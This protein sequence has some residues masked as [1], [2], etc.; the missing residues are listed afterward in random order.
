MGSWASMIQLI[1]AVSESASWCVLEWFPAGSDELLPLGTLVGVAVVEGSW[2][3]DVTTHLHAGSVTGSVKARHS[4]KESRNAPHFMSDLLV[5]GCCCLPLL[6][7]WLCME[8]ECLINEP[9]CVHLMLVALEQARGMATPV[10]TLKA[11]VV[12]LSCESVHVLT[13]SGQG[14]ALCLLGKHGGGPGSAWGSVVW[15]WLACTVLH[16]CCC[17]AV[18]PSHLFVSGHG[19][20]TWDKEGTH[21]EAWEHAVPL[22][23]DLP[24]HVVLQRPALTS[25][26]QLVLEL[27]HQ[28][29]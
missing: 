29:V 8:W 18:V 7:E 6:Y 3:R 23:W 16:P 11:G 1:P 28:E 14:F 24:E 27:L 17:G 13:V 12:H 2:K 21:G 9:S 10:A 19:N 25:W 5:V 15:A 4:W 26:V 20:W 22:G